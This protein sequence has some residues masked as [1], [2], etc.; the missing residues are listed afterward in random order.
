MWCI[1][2]CV[3]EESTENVENQYYKMTLGPHRNGLSLFPAWNEYSSSERKNI[4]RREEISWKVC[5]HDDDQDDHDDDDDDQE[6]L[7]PPKGKN[8]AR[9]SFDIFKSGKGKEGKI[10]CYLVKDDG[11]RK[12]YEVESEHNVQLCTSFGLR[13]YYNTILLWSPTFTI[14]YQKFLKAIIWSIAFIL[15]WTILSPNLFPF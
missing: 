14:P 1:V 15:P 11:N 3:C 8:E 6:E 13:R 9:K 5:Y 7:I 10:A 12:Y 2:L 4:G